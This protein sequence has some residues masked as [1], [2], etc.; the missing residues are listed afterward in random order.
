MFC[1]R[2]SSLA[3]PFNSLLPSRVPKF[4]AFVIYWLPVL[5]WMAVIFSASS[6]RMSF[7]H[8]SRII[9]PILHWLFPKMSDHSVHAVVFAV[10]KAAHVTEYAI[11]ALLVWRAL[12]KPSAGN[13]V[14]VAGGASVL[15]R[16]GST[17]SPRP[18]LWSHARFALIFVALYATSD[19]I[20]QAF[21]PTRQASIWDVL[22]DTLGG[23][24]GLLFLWIIGRW[25]KHW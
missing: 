23:A 7:S 21:V 25:R 9:A 12:R 6:D 15:P 4:R 20:H 13:R 11:L 10:R 24:F 22:L 17:S 2:I 19:E 1:N 3:S 5:I 16:A 14:S 18:W 8:S